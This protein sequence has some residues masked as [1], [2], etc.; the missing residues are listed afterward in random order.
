MGVAVDGANRN[1]CKLVERTLNSLPI[2]RPKPTKKRA[3]HMCSDTAMTAS[4]CCEPWPSTTS[5]PMFV[6]LERKPK[7][8]AAI[9]EGLGGG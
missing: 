6:A 4:S 7:G 9:V 5:S 8:V 2:R 3:Q 1:D